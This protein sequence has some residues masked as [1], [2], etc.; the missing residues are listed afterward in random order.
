MAPPWSST[1]RRLMASPRPMLVAALRRPAR[2]AEL[3]EDSF[4]FIRRDA[5][6][7]VAHGDN[8]RVAAASTA[9][10]TS[11]CSVNLMAFATR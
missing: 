3:I 2:A 10:N 11:P 4:L 5:Y 9:S 6:P 7:R 8:H 1:S